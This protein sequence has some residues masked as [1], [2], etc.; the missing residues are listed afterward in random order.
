MSA[1]LRPPL[2]QSRWITVAARHHAWVGD[3]G[4]HTS[5]PLEAAG[6]I[7]SE[8]AEVADALLD[9]PERQA[10]VREELADV[11]LRCFDLAH[12]LGVPLPAMTPVDW[13]SQGLLPLL[14]ALGPLLNACRRDP[15]ETGFAPALYAVIAETL[16]AGLLLGFSDLLAACEAKCEKN[17]LRGNRGRVK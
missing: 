4:W 11:L 12:R 1:A 13:H 9:G 14:R 6:L 8:V 5:T 17:R 7:A 3:M 15:P 10:D 2:D 16:R